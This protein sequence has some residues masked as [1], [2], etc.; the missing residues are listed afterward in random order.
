[1]TS[2]I[3]IV[4][5]SLALAAAASLGLAGCSG[6]GSGASTSGADKTTIGISF[7]N[8]V[9]FREGQKRFYQIAAKKL[10]VSLEFQVAQNDA[11]RQSSQ[12]KTMVSQGDQGIIIL[13]LD[14]VA[15][16]ADIK[17][18]NTAKVPVTTVDVAP[19]DVNSVK[20]HVGSD[21][22]ADGKAAAAEFVKLADGKPFKIVEMQGAL[23]SNTGVA[24]SKGLHDGLTGHD[25]V[26][27]VSIVPTDWKPEPALTGIQ[28]ALQTHSDLAGIYLPTDGQ[29]PAAYS[30]LSAVNKKVKVGEPG[31]VAIV[32]I[33]GDPNGC[34]GVKDAYVDLDLATDVPNMTLHSLQQT[35]NLVQGKPVSIKSPEYLPSIAVT[36]STIAANESKVWGCSQGG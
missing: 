21:P 4:S 33:D 20:F 2:K 11:Q 31:H 27:I 16:E 18:L 14:P 10:N 29:I 35:V 3:R 1:M 13:P 32:S 9:G 24:R 7:E 26:Q 36:P 5:L 30:A 28:N 17:T 25:N 19:K 22:L 8:G 15:I 12:I 34:Q 6:S 23:N